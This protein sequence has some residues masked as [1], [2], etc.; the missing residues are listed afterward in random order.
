MGK[1]YKMKSII[2]YI[3]IFMAGVAATF[4]YMNYGGK[5]HNYTAMHDSHHGA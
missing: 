4:F 2:T 3:S 5:N 1:I